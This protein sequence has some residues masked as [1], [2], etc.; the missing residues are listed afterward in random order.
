[1]LLGAA[2]VIGA[3]SLFMWNR[4]EA[5]QAAK[6]AQKTL[7]KLVKLLPPETI[8]PETTAALEEDAEAQELE[9][10]EMTVTEIDGYGYIGCL[11]I[12]ALEL[13][14]PVMSEWSYPQLKMSPC[15]YTGSVYSQNLVIAAHNYTRHFGRLQNLE[16]GDAVYFTDMDG[17][18]WEYAVVQAEVLMP[19][20]IE[21]M[22]A[23]EYA[24][25]LFTCTYGGRSRVTVRCEQTA[26]R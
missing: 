13:E 2:L 4:H 7:Q 26:G 5:G 17:R 3:L 10:R 24:L 21:E 20:A 15:R 22:T 1:M 8:P 25:T 9:A 16:A 23:G 19:A 12:P 6:N 11:S 18:V 14:L